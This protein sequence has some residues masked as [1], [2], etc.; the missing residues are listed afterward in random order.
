MAAGFTFGNARQDM[1]SQLIYKII[2]HPDPGYV[3]VYAIGKGDIDNIK[4][5]Y[6]EVLQ[7]LAKQRGI[8]RLW[9]FSRIDLSM[10]T[11]EDLDSFAS[12]IGASGLEDGNV[13][14]SAILL[15]DSLQDAIIRKLKT[16]IKDTLNADIIITKKLD[17]ALIWVLNGEE[18]T[19]NYR[20]RESENMTS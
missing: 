8:N 13:V 5:M 18:N 6:L 17:E 19:K 11:L 14:N 16:I 9:D 12:Y 20:L 2:H 10:I 15:R 1:E 7:S 3:R 4:K